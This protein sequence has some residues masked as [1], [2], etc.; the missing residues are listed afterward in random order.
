M[1]KTALA[2]ILLVA[3]I[4]AA[5]GETKARPTCDSSAE[6]SRNLVISFYTEALVEKQ[7]R[8]GFER[9]VSPRLVEHKPDVP[10]GDR[11]VVIDFL[12]N[13]VREVPDAQWEIIRTIA[14]KDLVFLH[15]RFTPAPGAPPYAIADVFRVENCQIVEHWDVVGPPRENMPNTNSR[16]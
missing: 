13:I 7:V 15:A 9:Y 8:S 6:G 12:E 2:S 4:G 14:E 16:F 11:A 10:A 1:L 5:A 3:W